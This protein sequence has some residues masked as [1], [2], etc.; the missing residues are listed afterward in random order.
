MAAATVRVTEPVG[1]PP[2]PPSPPPVTYDAF[3]SYSHL[4]Q[5]WVNAHLVPPLKSA[6]ISVCIDYADFEIGPFAI[7]NMK[8]SVKA[9][10][11]V[12]IVLSSSWLKSEWSKFEYLQASSEDPTGRG[13]KVLQILIEPT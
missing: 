11:H 6:G 3:I 10:R 13:R 1:P 2:G 12:I 9:S 5:A 7:E 8:N 4:D